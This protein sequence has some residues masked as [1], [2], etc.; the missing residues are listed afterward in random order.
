[1]SSHCLIIDRTKLVDAAGPI[2]K[3]EQFTQ[4]VAASEVLLEAR[5][6]AREIEAGAE[7]VLDSARREGYAQGVQQARAEL[8]TQIAQTTARLESA[9]VSLEARIVNTVMGAVQQI[10]RETDERTVM[11]RLIRR[12]LAERRAEKQLR[13]RVS[14]GQ[15]DQVNQWLAALLREFPDVEFIDVLKD[16]NGAPGTCVLES[17]F[18]VVDASLD[19]QL[20]AVRAGLVNA[21]VRGRLTGDIAEPTP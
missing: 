6:S 20:A 10:L 21:F 11:E 19:T 8:S 2:V 7:A 14:A 3:A 1:M 17:E 16:P 15:F 18:G 9:F 4:L 5:R 13:L 12:V